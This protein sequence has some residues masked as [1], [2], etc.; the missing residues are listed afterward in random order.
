MEP[1][2]GKSQLEFDRK[3]SIQPDTG[4]SNGGNRSDTDPDLGSAN[5]VDH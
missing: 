2:P 3:I 5:P 1:D 4:P